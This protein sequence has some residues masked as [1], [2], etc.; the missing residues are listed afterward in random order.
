[1]PS[2]APSPPVSPPARVAYTRW[3]TLYQP[4]LN[5]YSHILLWH[6]HKNTDNVLPLVN[7]VHYMN[8]YLFKVYLLTKTGNI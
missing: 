3:A 5:I 8:V 2:P 4:T 1:M 6:S 7:P